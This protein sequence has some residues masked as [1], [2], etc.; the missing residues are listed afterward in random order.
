M[1]EVD[2]KGNV[3]RDAFNIATDVQD[4]FSKN[5]LKKYLEQPFLAYMNARFCISKDGKECALKKF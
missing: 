3:K 1:T 5:K 4:S 2:E